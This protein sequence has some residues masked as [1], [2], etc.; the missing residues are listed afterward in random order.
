M[1]MKKVIEDQIDEIV[2]GITPEYR[3]WEG[4]II[5]LTDKHKD[6]FCYYFLVN[7]PSWWDDYLPPV[8]VN[9]AKFLEELYW[10]S[11]QTQISCILRDDIYLSLE[12][13]L[14]ELVQ[15]SYDRVYNVESEPFAGYERGQ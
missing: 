14:R 12:N 15:E 5:E 1:L 6:T 7:M 10:N 11:M 13:T 9:Q 2:R 4:D 8:I 3:S